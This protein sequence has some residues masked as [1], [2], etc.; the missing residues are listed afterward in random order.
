[1]TLQAIL[2][3]AADIPQLDVELLAAHVLGQDRVWLYAHTE[4]EFSDHELATLNQYIE[5]R[6]KHE[7]VAYIVG[8]QEFFGRDFRV[9][10]HVLIP[11][12]A[13]EVLVQLALDFLKTGNPEQ[14]EADSGITVVSHNFGDVGEAKTLVDV[15]T[16][17]GCIAITLAH[18]TQDTPIL[19][20]DMSEAALAI[21]Q[22]N[23][24]HHGLTEKIKFLQG[25]GLTPL[26]NWDDPF[27]L[28][29]N[30]PYIP[31]G[32]TLMPDVGFYEP[33]IALYAGDDGLAVLM[34]LIEAAKNH[35]ACRGI[36]LECRTDQIGKLPF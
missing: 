23:T 21:A 7:P 13:T 1:M 25:D 33:K 20:T 9:T 32:E 15:G 4:H 10:P 12:P 36:V 26:E 24:H 19:A 11:R 6:R 30:P 14:R 8:K 29:S 5:R 22:V 17:S 35:P 16:G 18:E 28:V 2:K 3:T 31:T 27:I 34:P